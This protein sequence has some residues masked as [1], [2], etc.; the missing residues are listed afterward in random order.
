MSR[1]CSRLATQ[2]GTPR[3]SRMTTRTWSSPSHRLIQARPSQCQSLNPSEL[4]YV[5]FST[6]IEATCCQGQERAGIFKYSAMAKLHGM[7][8][9]I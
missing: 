5:N 6:K 7:C 9:T 8:E 2:T 1:N 4:F 3:S